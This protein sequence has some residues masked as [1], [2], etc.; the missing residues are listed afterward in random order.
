MSF[1][2]GRRGQ[3]PF[4]MVILNSHSPVRQFPCPQHHPIARNCN[5]CISFVSTVAA[6]LG[7]FLGFV[8]FLLLLFRE[9]FRCDPFWFQ[10]H[11]LLTSTS[12]T[13]KLQVCTMTIAWLNNLR[14][15]ERW[16]FKILGG[17]LFICVFWFICVFRL[18]L[19]LNRYL[20]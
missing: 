8:F 11:G 4:K 20:Y 7:V 10:T 2:P 18:G 6:C 13:V 16:Y 15:R 9:D 17:D 14:E 3:S 19:I 12:Q 1:F 5:F